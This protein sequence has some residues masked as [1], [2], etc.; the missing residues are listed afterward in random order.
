MAAGSGSSAAGA[1][2]RS[3]CSRV[4]TATSRAA[5]A[6]SARTRSTRR[7]EATVI[8][9]PRGLSGR[10]VGLPLRGGRRQGF[11]GRVLAV[12]EVAVPAQQGGKDVR[13]LPAPHVLD[14]RAHPARARQASSPPTV[15]VARSSTVSPGP[16]KCAHDLLGPLLAL[17]VDQEEA[18][19][20]LL[21]LG[22]RAVGHQRLA[23]LP[24][25]EPGAGRVGQRL[26][27]DELAPFRQLGQHGL[28]L[29]VQRLAPLGRQRLVLG[30][31]V[32]GRVP[33]GLGVGV[34]QDDVLHG[35]FLSVTAGRSTLHPR[36]R[37]RA[38]GSRHH[39]LAV[40]EK[41][42]DGVG[43]GLASRG[44]REGRVVEG[45]RA[46]RDRVRA[47]RVRPVGC[48]PAV[49]AAAG[50]GRGDRDPGAPDRLVVP[51]LGGPGGDRRASRLLGAGWRTGARC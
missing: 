38:V 49:L 43:Q 40:S 3:T 11:L 2:S 15:I 33:P 19:E 27:A 37:S 6:R 36:R 34:D 21:R 31:E 12:A 39:H 46:A 28:E 8:S 47:R 5:R 4:A 32:P 42:Q 16:E 51:H 20:V 17:D 18:G 50:P 22:V 25:V 9:Q 26:A 29:V 24:A 7:R 1:S 14:H 30:D 10:P 45:A 44:E 23:G 35:R 41:G 48:G 13:R